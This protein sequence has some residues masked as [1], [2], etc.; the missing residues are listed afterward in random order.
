MKEI[1]KE[2]NNGKDFVIAFGNYEEIKNGK[3]IPL[4]NNLKIKKILQE[5]NINEVNI[6]NLS[7]ISSLY[8]TKITIVRDTR[9]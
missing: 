8:T 1:V 2:L 5:N 3:V 9:L 4:T 6:F 7:P